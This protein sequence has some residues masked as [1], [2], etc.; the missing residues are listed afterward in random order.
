MQQEHGESAQEQRIALYKSKSNIKHYVTVKKSV[1]AQRP[2]LMHD[3]CIIV[4]NQ[5]RMTQSFKILRNT[6]HHLLY[7]QMC[8]NN[9]HTEMLLFL[10]MYVFV[11]P[12]TSLWGIYSEECICLLQYTFHSL[13]RSFTSLQFQKAF[14]I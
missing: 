12:S 9:H 8:S 14:L 7:T 13:S 3:F 4:H 10:C 5:T 11:L 6:Y 1:C 2:C